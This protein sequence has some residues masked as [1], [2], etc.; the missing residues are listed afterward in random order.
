VI[1]ISNEP[2]RV[3][4]SPQPDDSGRSEYLSELLSPV[5]ALLHTR[6]ARG[7]QARDLLRERIRARG[8]LQGAYLHF[9]LCDFDVNLPLGWSLSDAAREDMNQ[10]LTGYKDEEYS[11]RTNNQINLQLVIDLLQGNTSVTGVIES[12]NCR[13]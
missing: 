9:Q 3:I 13:R 4:S 2:R 10:Q 12:P 1:H 6:T 8:D 7:F 11:E 5:R